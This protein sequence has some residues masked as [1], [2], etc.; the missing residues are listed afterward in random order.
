[1]MKPFVE[2]KDYIKFYTN[3]IVEHIILNGH[4]ATDLSTYPTT[5]NIEEFEIFV[6]KLNEN[7]RIKNVC[8]LNEYI[9]PNSNIA[10]DAI[11]EEIQKTLVEL[12]EHYHQPVTPNG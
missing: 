10:R 7:K 11:K 2:T 6:K 4:A 3:A 1:M 9:S 8:T 12:G 5:E